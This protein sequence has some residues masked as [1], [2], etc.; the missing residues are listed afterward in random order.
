M[1][2]A[3]CSRPG[4]GGQ[5]AS[6]HE[7]ARKSMRVLITGG[8]GLLGR[9]LAH[10][11]EEA[12][13]KVLIIDSRPPAA[14]AYAGACEWLPVD[15]QRMGA[16][17]LDASVRSCDCIVHLAATVGVE[18]IAKNIAASVVNNFES[19]RR[20]IDACRRRGKFLVLFS[21]SE[22]YGTLQSETDSFSEE[23]RLVLGSPLVDGLRGGY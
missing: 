20:V 6:P 1:P 23:D 10:T 3:T 19:S 21:T 13:H 12:G 11:L 22:V 15:I 17:D 8:R 4:C 5:S 16:G 7:T 2:V 14:G 9:N 18:T